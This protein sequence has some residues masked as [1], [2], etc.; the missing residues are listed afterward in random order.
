MICGKFIVLKLQ[1]IQI[2]KKD[3]CKNGQDCVIV[4]IFH[5]KVPEAAL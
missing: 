5:F 1:K 2:K 3:I 4:E